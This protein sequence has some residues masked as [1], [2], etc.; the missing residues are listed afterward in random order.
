MSEIRQ[1][2]K[3]SLLLSL[4]CCGFAQAQFLPNNTQLNPQSVQRWM[5]SNRDFA[6]LVQ[7]LDAMHATEADLKGFDSLPA[8][9]QDQKI[10]QF[11]QQKKLLA[12]ANSIAAK[13][14]WKS[15]GEYM[16]LGSTL[17]NAIAAYFLADSMANLNA[18][19][20]LL[21]REK[22]DPAVLAVPAA[23]ISFVKANEKLLQQYMQAYS[24]GR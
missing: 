17:G 24:Q 4:L 18:E 19:Q 6:P 9:T 11:L 5:D 13:R 10:D 8:A 16:R 3:W 2:Y 22:A 15:I 23:D 7:A 21:L 14:G 12:T 20:K 1:L